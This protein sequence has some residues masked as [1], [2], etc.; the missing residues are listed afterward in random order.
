M[1]AT[2]HDRTGN[3]KYD[4]VSKRRALTKLGGDSGQRQKPVDK[5]MT[6]EQQLSSTPLNSQ[7]SRAEPVAK[8]GCL[9]PLR[10]GTARRRTEALVTTV[11]EASATSPME[12][13]RSATEFRTPDCFSSVAFETPGSQL[14]SKRTFGEVG[15]HDFHS[16]SLSSSVTV[17][18]RIRPFMTRSVF[19]LF[20][21][22]H[23]KTVN[24]CVVLIRLS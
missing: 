1:S 10:S 3:E 17:A 24:S 12:A 19:C 8:S 16:E 21:N 15:A 9:P 22:I 14:K 7:Q 4:D 18:V 2:R 11:S 13:R 23:F 5:A 20:Q 6:S